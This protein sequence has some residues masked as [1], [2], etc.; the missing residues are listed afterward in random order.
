MSRLASPGEFNAR[1]I[2]SSVIG[3]LLSNRCTSRASEE[4]RANREERNSGDGL[5]MDR[6]SELF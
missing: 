3:R 6:E 5:M 1:E 2:A 4:T